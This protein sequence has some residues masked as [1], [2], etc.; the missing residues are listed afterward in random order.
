M[1]RFIILSTLVLLF[2][3]C[4]NSIKTKQYNF[5]PVEWTIAVPEDFV[6]MN[7]S[8]IKAQNEKGLK[9][10]EKA[11]DTAIEINPTRTLISLQK[12]K[13]NN[14]SAT[15]TSFDPKTD[16]SWIDVNEGLKAI[17]YQTFT[18]QM[19][20]VVVDTSSSVETIDGLEFQVFRSKLTYPNKMVMN[21]FLYSKLYKGYDF[22]ISMAYVDEKAGK[23]LKAILA[24]S[25]FKK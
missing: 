12:D 5:P 11:M 6:P 25:V 1:K 21:S 20:G 2:A 22:G 9:V 16:G 15:I 19:P 17:I 3:G 8:E 24:S 7:T 14:F 23:E 4:K 18:T 10:I 13:L